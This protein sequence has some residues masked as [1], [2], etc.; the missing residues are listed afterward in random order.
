DVELVLFESHE[1]SNLP[2]AATIAGLDQ[3]QKEYDLTYTVH[4]PLDC[5]LGTP[6]Q[7]QRQADIGKCLRTFEL[8]EPL[9]PHAFI[10]HLHGEERGQEPARDI[11]KWQERLLSSVRSLLDAG[12]P[13]RM[14]AVETLDYPFHLALPIIEECGLSVCIDIGH[15]LLAGRD[16]AAHIK[17]N[18]QRCRVIHLHGV[19]EGKDHVDIESI[20][21]A[22]LEAIFTAVSDV[23]GPECVITLEVFD[24]EIFR[25]SAKKMIDFT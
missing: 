19:R 6:D 3:L 18:R 16:A 4:L 11:G 22:E 7:S 15:L 14:L 24:E 23:S 17:E 25:K 9:A 20:D 12:V 2:D 21:N 8:T 13:G 5:Q 10:L 1:F